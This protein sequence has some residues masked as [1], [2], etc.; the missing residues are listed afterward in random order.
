MGAVPGI[1]PERARKLALDQAQREGLQVMGG[2]V[3]MDG[4][5]QTPVT[6][7][8]ERRIGPD[9]PA[10]PTSRGRMFREAIR[11]GLGKYADEPVALMRD[12]SG[13]AALMASVVVDGATKVVRIPFDDMA[14]TARKW[15]T[16]ERK[17]RVPILG[18]KK[19]SLQFGPDITYQPAPGAK[20]IYR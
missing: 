10:D 15:I 4:K 18:I 6:T 19:E 5:N 12:P 1:T 14:A 7:E 3:W 17:P 13:A 8:V 16:E 9:V 20:S 2:F 11:A